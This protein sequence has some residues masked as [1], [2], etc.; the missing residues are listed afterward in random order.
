MRSSRKISFIKEFLKNIAHV[1]VI[2][3]QKRGLPHVHMLVIFDE[4]D[5]LN[6]PED[7]DCVV[8]AEI[9]DKNEEPELYAAV[10][11]HMIHGP[12]GQ[13]NSNAPCMK[14]MSCKKATLNH[15][16]NVLFKEMIR[17]RFIDD[18]MTTDL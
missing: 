11:K 4:D 18:V 3:F 5:K 12:C 8:R 13:S 1:H 15:L 9:P 6:T 17:I 16:Q 14:N 10:L 2:E 7:Y